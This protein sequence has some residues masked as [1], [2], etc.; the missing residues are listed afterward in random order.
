VSARSKS[1]KR[2]LDVLYAADLRG[3]APEVVLVELVAERTAARDSLN[4]YTVELVEGVQQHQERIDELLMTHA[5]GWA[6]DRMP[7]VDRN[8]LRM[9]IFE[10]LWGHEVP[11]AVAVSEAV[12]LATEIST[13]DSPRF[14]NG[15]L[16]RILQ[17]K[18]MLPE[19]RPPAVETAAVETAAVDTD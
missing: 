3:V 16:G 11:D 15:L 19:G 18:P 12:E 8:V 2:A 14:V 6:T 17:L 7:V 10:I 9:G 13:D 4:P 1:R 5:E